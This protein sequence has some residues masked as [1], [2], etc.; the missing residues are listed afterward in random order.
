VYLKNTRSTSRKAARLDPCRPPLVRIRMKAK[1]F[2]SSSGERR[3]PTRR[4][5]AQTKPAQ[6]L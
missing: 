5:V 2:S 4:R 1:L 6:A 3:D